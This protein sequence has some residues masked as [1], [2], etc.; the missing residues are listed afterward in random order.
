MPSLDL[1]A[2]VAQ[3]LILQRC[4]D[5]Q[6]VLSGMLNVAVGDAGLLKWLMDA[7]VHYIINDKEVYIVHY[8]V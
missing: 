3:V 5:E 7:A 4:A 1:Q 8:V 6:L 2:A